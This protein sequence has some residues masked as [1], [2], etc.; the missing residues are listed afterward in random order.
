MSAVQKMSLAAHCRY[1]IP[2]KPCVASGGYDIE[3]TSTMRPALYRCAHS[4]RP[5]FF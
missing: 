3:D 5:F 2:R 1:H 4:Y